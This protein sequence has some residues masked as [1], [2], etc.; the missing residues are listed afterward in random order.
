MLAKQTWN[1]LKNYT[2]GSSP[3]RATLGGR[4]GESV[5]TTAEWI[6]TVL[7][8][9]IKKKIKIWKKGEALNHCK[10]QRQRTFWQAFK[11]ESCR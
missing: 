1:L 7:I 9:K 6:S 8:L 10:L 2:E 11:A 3:G 4:W 5:S